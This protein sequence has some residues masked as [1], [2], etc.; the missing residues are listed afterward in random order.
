MVAANFLCTLKWVQRMRICKPR[1]VLGSSGVNGLTLLS[2]QDDAIVTAIPPPGL[3][4]PSRF[5]KKPPPVNAIKLEDL[6]KELTGDSSTP[7]QQVPEG[8]KQ[9]PRKTMIG[10]PPPG[11]PRPMMTPPGLPSPASARMV[12]VCIMKI[13]RYHRIITQYCN[14]KSLQSTQTNHNDSIYMYPLRLNKARWKLK[15]DVPFWANSTVPEAC[16][17]QCSH[18]GSL[19]LTLKRL[20]FMF[21]PNGRRGF[22]SHNQVFPWLS[23]ALYCFYTKKSSFMSVLTIGIIRDCFYLII[24]YSEKFSTW[25]WRLP[26]AVNVNLNLSIYF[27]FT[28]ENIACPLDNL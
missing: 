27:V 23:F 18:A 17:A 24:F 10:Q 21:T 5:M 13:L 12:S 9:T 7:P 28:L 22:V 11:I 26:F 25:D 2:L 3:I 4:P 1:V 19:T 16:L 14:V 8:P 15:K 6:E 20:I